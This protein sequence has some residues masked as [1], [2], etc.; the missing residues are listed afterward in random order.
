MW[1]VNS[2][3]TGAREGGV[4][5]RDPSPVVGVVGV[6]VG[7]T[8]FLQ[9]EASC[10]RGLG[11]THLL[12]RGSRLQEKTMEGQGEYRAWNGAWGSL[13]M[14]SLKVGITRLISPK[15][16]SGAPRDEVMDGSQSQ[17]WVCLRPLSS[18]MLFS[19]SFLGKANAILLFR[20]DWPRDLGLGVGDLLRAHSQ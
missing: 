4:P 20:V 17:T 1:G 15:E 19:W 12:L 18:L 7:G 6:R 11:G 2:A 8:Q 3:V 10:V 14:T 13:G 9:G 16:E 5:S